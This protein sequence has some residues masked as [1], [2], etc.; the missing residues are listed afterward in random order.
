MLCR[1]RFETDRHTGNE[2]IHL[3]EDE[4]A[5]SKTAIERRKLMIIIED[6]RI[7]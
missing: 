1:G 7:E 4:K 5:R 6:K 2:D 3:V